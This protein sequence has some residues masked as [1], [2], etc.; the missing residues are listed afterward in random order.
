MFDTVEFGV[1]EVEPRFEVGVRARN[2]RTG[3]NCRY[4]EGKEKSSHEYLQ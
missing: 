1:D 4:E 3:I 2:E